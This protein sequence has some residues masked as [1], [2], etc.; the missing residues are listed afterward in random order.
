[1]KK[2]LANEVPN[3]IGLKKLTE[4]FDDLILDKLEAQFANKSQEMLF[5]LGK[6]INDYIMR[7]L[8]SLL[9][10]F[11]RQLNPTDVIY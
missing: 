6:L 1:M 9:W 4:K 5:E 7:K 3:Y 8:S 11:N 2:V 10:H